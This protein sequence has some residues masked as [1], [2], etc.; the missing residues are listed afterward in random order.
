MKVKV[1][2]LKNIKYKGLPQY[3]GDSVE[4]DKEDLQE[5]IKVEVISDE[6]YEE[7]EDIEDDFEDEEV[8]DEDILDIEEVTKRQITSKLTALGIEHNARGRKEDLYEL[9]LK[10]Q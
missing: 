3:V 8:S 7:L 9:L 1:K 5:F 6:G 4:V 2:L 10:H